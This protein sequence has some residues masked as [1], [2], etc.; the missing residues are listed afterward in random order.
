MKRWWPAMV[1]GTLALVLTA[2][3]FHLRRTPDPTIQGR[4]LSAWTEDL[5]SPDYTRR[6][7]AQATL[8]YLGTPALP[9]IRRLLHREN[10]G[11]E[12]LF[13]RVNR[14]VALPRYRPRDAVL[15]RE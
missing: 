9:Q 6:S 7:D 1:I 2:A 8:L 3:A 5:L 15:C 11:W 14:R 13:A 12:W 10:R 4:L